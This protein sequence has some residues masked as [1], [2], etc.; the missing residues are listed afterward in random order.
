M[1]EGTFDG[2][3]RV[4]TRAVMYADRGNKIKSGVE[5]ERMNGG[6]KTKT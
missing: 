3:G 4:D 6:T 1:R 5:R 2:Q